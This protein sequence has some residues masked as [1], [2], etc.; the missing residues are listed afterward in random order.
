MKYCR[1]LCY[2]TLF[3]C[4][5]S[6]TK[7]ANENILDFFPEQYSLS[8]SEFG[9]QNDS[10]AVIEGLFCSDTSL[11]VIDHCLGETYSLFDAFTGDFITRFGKIG[12]GPEEIPMYSSGYPDKGRFV[13]YYSSFG[14]GSVMVY[15]V[16]S[17]KS[18]SR[19]KTSLS[20]KFSITDASF[21]RIIMLN[22]STFVGVGLYLGEYLYVMFN[23]RGEIIDY[24]IKV[25]NF[26]DDNYNI[27]HR[28]LSNQGYIGKHPL[29][30]KFVYALTNSS[31]IDFMNVVDDKF[32]LVK[33]IHAGDPQLIPGSIELMN[34]VTPKDNSIIGFI[35]LSVT[36]NYV[37]ALYVDKTYLDSNDQMNKQCSN[38]VL[39]F[40]WNGNPV[41]R[42]NLDSEA[43][44]I[45]VNELN[46][47]LY[48]ASIDSDGGWT[49]LTYPISH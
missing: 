2:S 20:A 18:N 21:S 49:I 26:G 32:D 48:A 1:L 24:S 23:N 40:D 10:L 19:K 14:V 27:F 25:F 35:D 41:K 16:D 36:R 34:F 7:K 44:Y 29:E 12:Q 38:I 22:D 42:Y 6:C 43:Y 9:I 8:E 13:S 39:V 46:N 11:F 31:N 33:S 45:G 30:N 47:K 37:Y 28:Y 3:L 17:L 4:L 15:E 5:F